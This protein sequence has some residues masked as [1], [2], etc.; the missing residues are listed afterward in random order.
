VEAHGEGEI[1]WYLS[2]T[3]QTVSIEALPFA[4]GTLDGACEVQGSAPNLVIRTG[5]GRFGIRAE[6]ANGRPAA[7]AP[8]SIQA[9]V[10]ET[11]V[12]DGSPSCDPE[13]G[14]LNYAWSLRSAPAGSRWPLAD[15]SAP[16]ATM[17]PDVAGTYRVALQV[18]DSEGQKSDP[19]FVSIEVP[20]H[21]E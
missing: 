13:G 6:A 8:V 4:M 10:G 9:E 19:A 1:E 3:P 16:R 18:M 11:V 7:V 2:P 21:A 5:G 17:V 15:T 20:D 12:L 14:P